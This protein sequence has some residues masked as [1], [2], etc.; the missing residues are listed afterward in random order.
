[1]LPL[2]IYI[3]TSKATS[4]LTRETIKYYKANFPEARLIVCC[5]ADDTQSIQATMMAN[6]T[7]YNWGP[8]T[9]SMKKDLKNYLW[10]LHKTPGWCI[11]AENGTCIKMT[12]KDIEAEEA[13]GSTIL[14]MDDMVR[15]MCFRQDQ[16]KD[17]ITGLDIAKPNPIGK[18]KY[19]ETIYQTI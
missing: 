6:C 12:S 4:Q 19:S 3:I 18:V 8:S 1:M 16:I 15:T 2:I 5:E 14:Q 13:S 17:F 10:K 11:Y 9:P 7:I